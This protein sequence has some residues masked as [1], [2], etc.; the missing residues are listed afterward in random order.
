MLQANEKISNLLACCN[1]A[2]LKG[3]AGSAADLEPQEVTRLGDEWKTILADVHDQ[4]GTQG[5]LSTD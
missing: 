3:Y 4:S 2:T 1:D 5:K